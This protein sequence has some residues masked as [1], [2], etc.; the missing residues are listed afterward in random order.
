MRVQPT[1]GPARRP[2]T[3]GVPAVLPPQAKD[4]HGAVQERHLD[5]PP[6]AAGLIEH[7]LLATPRGRKGA[8]TRS[9]A[10]RLATCE[11]THQMTGI[12]QQFNVHH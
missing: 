12:D 1:P 2:L 9:D 4:A 11:V 8:E 10:Q 6:K 5:I 7:L 3:H